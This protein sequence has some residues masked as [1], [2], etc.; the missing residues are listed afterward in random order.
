[1]KA[2][3]RSTRQILTGILLAAGACA[4][5]QDT[6]ASKTAT[7]DSQ[8]AEQPTQ[9][10]TPKPVIDVAWSNRHVSGDFHNY[11]RYGTPPNGPYL[12]G[13]TFDD[14]T[15]D[16]RNS[17]FLWLRTPGE[18]DYLAMARLDFNYGRTWFSFGDRRNKF[19]DPT[20]VVIDKSQREIGDFYARQALSRNLSIALRGVKDQQDEFFE[21]PQDSFRQR[22]Y[23]WSG[24]AGGQI[25]GGSGSLQFTDWHYFDRTNVL[26]DTRVQMW[27]ATYGRQL[28]NRLNAEASYYHSTLKP[29]GGAGNNVS[30]V[31]VTAD[32]DIDDNTLALFQ[33]RREHLHL[34]TVQNAFV[35][36]RGYVRGSVVH[37]FGGWNTEVSYRRMDLERVNAGH[38]FVD[39]P[40]F[41]TFEGR[42]SGKLSPSVRMTARA[43][44]ETL[45]GRFGMQTSDNRALYWRNRLYGQVA[46]D[47]TSDPND[48]YLIFTFNEK[49]ND[50]RDSRVR[51]QSVT[52]GASTLVRPGFDLYFEATNDTWSARTSDPNNPNLGEFFPD[53]SVYVLGTNLTFNPLAYATINYTEFFTDNP[54]PLGLAQGNVRAQFLTTGFH[55]RSKQGY[56]LGLSLVPW[57]F[58]DKLF[59]QW[60][61]D[62]TLITLSANVKF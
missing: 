25:A 51:D 49:R 9:P 14:W 23:T 58:T 44:R 61:Y 24:D 48:L 15:E 8:A 62:S 35:R 37:H 29:S 4:F 1:M 11:M 39:A 31:G 54:N 53:S 5:A 12:R 22:T 6:D 36:D 46:F 28:T 52:L 13:L 26:P 2:L 41:H 17:G 55:V 32:Y 60:G 57:K 50:P 18:P 43:V 38:T 34:P 16:F 40:T 27:G 47:A 19:Y 33:Y 10:S 59:N 56:E 45:D 30:A 21:P 3:T 20:P 42:V 7:S